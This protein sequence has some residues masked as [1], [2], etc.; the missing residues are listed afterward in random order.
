MN[1]SLK[2]ILAALTS[3]GVSADRINNAINEL[4]S[5]LDDLDNVEVMG[6]HMV[7]TMLGCMMAIEA[8]IGK[9]GENNS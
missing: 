8:I 9:D 5:M 6:R 7:D 1:Y 3:I 2:Q 4:S